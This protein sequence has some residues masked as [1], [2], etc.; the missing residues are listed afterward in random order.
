MSENFTLRVHERRDLRRAL[1]RL[2]L[3]HDEVW[4]ADQCDVGEA[5]VRLA[6][7]NPD[8]LRHKLR[9]VSEDE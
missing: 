2:S 9:R 1:D 4:D 6:L 3:E 5:I 7:D 8:L